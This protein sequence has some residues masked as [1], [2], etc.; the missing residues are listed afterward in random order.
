[1]MTYVFWAI[2]YYIKIFV[3]SSGKIKER[4]YETL[5]QWMMSD[6]EGACSRLLSRSAKLVGCLPVLFNLYKSPM[7]LEA[8]F[9]LFSAVLCS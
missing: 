3:V 9:V 4:N 5:Y 7:A 2:F 8:Q 1:M 6:P